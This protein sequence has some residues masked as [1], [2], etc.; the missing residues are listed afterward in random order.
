MQE[1]VEN[2]FLAE[3]GHQKIAL[4]Y[5][6]VLIIIKFSGF[7][8][9][10]GIKKIQ[11][12]RKGRTFETSSRRYFRSKEQRKVDFPLVLCSLIRTFVPQ[13]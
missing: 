4:T 5:V 12:I 13:I 6:K 11:P 3:E 9:E 2:L 10:N 8:F 7:S 1:K